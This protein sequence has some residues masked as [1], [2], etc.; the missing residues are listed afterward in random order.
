MALLSGALVF[1]VTQPLKRRVDAF[2]YRRSETKPSNESS[3][4]STDPAKPASAA[5]KSPLGHVTSYS[6]D[7]CGWGDTHGRVITYTYD[8]PRTT[9]HVYDKH[10]RVVAICEDGQYRFIG[11]D[12]ARTTYINDAARHRM[13]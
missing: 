6:Y 5:Q 4:P 12:H 10:G 9:S 1:E 7:G 3:M 8:Q 13:F 11:L 2:V